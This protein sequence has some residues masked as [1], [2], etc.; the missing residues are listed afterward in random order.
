MA[1]VT[2]AFSLEYPEGRVLGCEGLRGEAVHLGKDYRPSRL[3]EG[4]L[5]VGRLAERVGG[6]FQIEGEEVRIVPRR[7]GPQRGHRSLVARSVCSGLRPPAV[8]GKARSS[9]GRRDAPAP[10]LR[11]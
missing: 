5:V 2:A 9:S 8:P 4:A 7:I 10:R 6:G 11:V 3:E 1:E